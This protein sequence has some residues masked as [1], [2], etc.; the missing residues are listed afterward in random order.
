MAAAATGV[1]VVT[2]AVEMSERFVADHPFL[3]VIRDARTGEPSLFIG[4]NRRPGRCP[5]A[6]ARSRPW[7]RAPFPGPH[8]PPERMIPT[9]AP[10]RMGSFPP[11]TAA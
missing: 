7:P 3:F 4:Q 10:P 9:R 2:F 5:D 1:S 11:A 8:L 6:E